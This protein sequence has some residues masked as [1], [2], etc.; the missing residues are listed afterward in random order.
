MNFSNKWEELQVNIL[1]NEK[2]IIE[3][4]AKK[5]I[6]DANVKKLKMK[7]DKLEHAMQGMSN[8]LCQLHP[9]VF[10]YAKGDKYVV[11]TL[12]MSWL[13]FAIVVMVRNL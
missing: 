6:L 4:E 11:L 2:D 9:E 13:I 8:E 5:K 1:E 7:R 3:L 12:V 10:K